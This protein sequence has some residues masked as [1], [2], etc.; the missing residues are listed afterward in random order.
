MSISVR[1]AAAGDGRIL[2]AMV[3][4]LARNHGHTADFTAAPEDYERFLA[5]PQA[6]NGA[7]IGFWQG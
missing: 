2:H 1:A 3:H 5:D 6:I 7:I 4:E